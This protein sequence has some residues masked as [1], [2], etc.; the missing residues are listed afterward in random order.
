MKRLLCLLA[1]LWSGVSGAAVFE[2]FLNPN[3]PRDRAILNYLELEKQGKATSNDFAELAVLLVEKGFPQDGETYLRKALAADK[4]NVEA[5]YRLGLVL[6][7]LGRDWAAAREYRRVVKE[8]PG[9][10]EAQFMLG[11]ALERSGHRRAAVRAYAKAYKHNPALADPAK[12]PLVLDSKLQTQA[13]LLRYRREVTSVTLK[14]QPLDPQ[15][16]KRMMLVRV[17]LP[18]ERPETTPE[19]KGKPPAPSPTV[20]PTVPKKATS[21]PPPEAT[22][23]SEADLPA[24]A[25]PPSQ[26][27]LLP[28]ENAS[29]PPKLRR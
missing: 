20:S 25:T 2:R 26:K 6:Q 16:V 23:I 4:K 12:N 9:F 21:A 27:P 15:A 17:T 7:R 24:G 29:R 1:V 5:R 28:L 19:V 18:P 8:R 14:L 22:D 13:Q 3:V 10:A 11:L